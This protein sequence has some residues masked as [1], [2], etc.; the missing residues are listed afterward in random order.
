MQVNENGVISF[1][2][3]W[4]YSYPE[5]FPTED[6]NVRNALGVAPF[7]SDN[8][9]RK[10]GTVRYASY[11]SITDDNSRG[12]ALLDVVNA[13]IQGLQGEESET[14]FVGLWMLVAQWDG[15]HPSPHGADDL[16]GIDEEELERVRIAAAKNRPF[17][18]MC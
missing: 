7:W 17:W 9:I 8:D 11:D 14:R 15:V 18:N 1:E 13:N 2:N 5:Q 3:P 10:D 16:G 4:M 12:R 6:F